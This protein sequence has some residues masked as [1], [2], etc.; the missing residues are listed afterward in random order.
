[1]QWAPGEAAVTGVCRCNNVHMCVWCG[2]RILAANAQAMA[3][4][5]SAAGYG[6]HLGTNTLRHFARQPFDSNRK[7]QRFGLV[8][9]LHDG[10]RG[11]YA[12]TGR[13]WRRMKAEF[14]I[15][16]Y[17]RAYE[18]TWGPDTGGWGVQDPGVYPR[19]VNL[20]D[21]QPEDM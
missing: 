1:M 11:A 10:W 18:D 7:G 14:G 5:L 2:A 8:A 13:P 15:I 12:A 16:G 9:V 4:G 3:D 17:E 20:P 19:P 6:L 21:D